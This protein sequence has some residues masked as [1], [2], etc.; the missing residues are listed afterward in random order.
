MKE[1]IFMLKGELN[2]YI[3]TNTLEPI[4]GLLSS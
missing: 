3:Q 1:I 4:R 2:S